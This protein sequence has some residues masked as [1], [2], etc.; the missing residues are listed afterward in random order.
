MRQ[1]LFLPAVLLLTGCVTTLVPHAPYLPAVEKR[2][3]VEVQVA[4]N[5]LLSKTDLQLGYQATER[6]V[7]H[8]AFMGAR[9]SGGRTSFLS[10]EAGAGY[11]YA[12]P[13]QPWRLGLDAGAAHGGGSSA[14][15]G[16][17]E[18]AGDP[19]PLSE[20]YRVRYTY[21]YVQPT[22]LLKTGS[23]SW[24][25]ALRLGQ[26]YYHRLREVRVDSVGS[27]AQ[28][29]NH[30]GHQSGFVQPVF[31]LRYQVQPWLL[32]SGSISGIEFLGPYSR[33]NI[34]GPAVVQVGAQFVLG[35]ST[36]F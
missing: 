8:T 30:A 28:E 1:L 22:V 36:S 11:Y 23:L 13:N 3:E 6:W 16:C 34:A 26:T 25:L 33:L 4:S 27:Q 7:L 18:C 2:G 12:S 21:G 29:T 9:P 19:Y 15:S 20:S 10:G 32:A 17:F 24:G 14:R 31:Q 35:K 5:L